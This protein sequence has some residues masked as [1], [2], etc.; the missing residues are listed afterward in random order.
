MAVPEPAHGAI[1]LMGRHAYPARLMS[2][3]VEDGAQQIEVTEY[4]AKARGCGPLPGTAGLMLA[5]TRSS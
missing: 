3:D 2:L 1:A 4:E 5:P